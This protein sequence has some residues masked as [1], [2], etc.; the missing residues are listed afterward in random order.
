[1]HPVVAD[2]RSLALYFTAWLLL[3]LLLGLP[4]LGA[5]IGA[6]RQVL[7]LF[8]PPYFFY[9]FLGLAAWFPC[10]ANPIPATPMPRLL[11]VHLSA[12][13]VSSALWW[14][15][16][17]LWA[18]ALAAF[19]PSIQHGAIRPD[20]ARHLAVGVLLYL[21]ATAFQYLLLAFEASRQAQERS[22]ELR[23][24]A[25]EAELAAFKSQ[26]DPHFLFNCLN[27]IS[28]LCGTEPAAARKMSIRLGEF[29]RSSLR[30]ADRDFITLGEEVDLARSYMEIEQV[31]FG[32]RLDFEEDIDP[33]ILP[34]EVPALVLQP[35]L[36]NSIKHGLAH[37]VNGGTITLSGRRTGERLELS[38]ENPVDPESRPV[39][40]DGIGLANVSGRL[41]LLYLGHG[42]IEIERGDESF[43]ITLDLPVRVG[44]SEATK[45]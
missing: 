34:I 31:R 39:E 40:G 18:R 23:V 30:L 41:E 38:V 4:T 2:K 11:A 9:G 19:L 16:A 12:A 14:G 29:L 5:D 1:M 43:R 22:L 33:G 35:L 32:D 25:R 42:R 44:E 36:E 3:G 26:I 45:T 20:P 17:D 28:A 37:L 13:L 15:A 8:L 7:A 24:L 27:S 10:H 6:W 21:L